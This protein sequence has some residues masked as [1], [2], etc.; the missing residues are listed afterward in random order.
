[1]A[2]VSPAGPLPMMMTF[3]IPILVF[4]RIAAGIM[5]PGN[6]ATSF[7]A[8]R[9]ANIPFMMTSLLYSR[10]PSGCLALLEEAFQAVDAANAASLLDLSATCLDEYAEEES[11]RQ[12]SALL[13]EAAAG[14]REDL[15][16]QALA[17]LANGRH[18]K[19]ALA[20]H[21]DVLARAAG[22][23]DRVEDLEA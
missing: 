11:F 12:V 10:M 20:R 18:L 21:A 14:G 22:L 23:R 6:T 17:R 19:F 16:T 7:R 13:R 8:R 1:M 3:S 2:A 9:L 15:Q 5:K 4:L